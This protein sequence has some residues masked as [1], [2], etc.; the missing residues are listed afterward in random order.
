VPVGQ[1]AFDVAGRGNGT[2]QYRVVG[3][4][5]VEHGLIEGPASAART[6]AVD[7][8]YEADVTS[9]I[10]AAMVD[11]TVSFAGGVFQ[12]DQTLRNASAD[13]AVFVPLR[14]TITSVSSRS[15]KVKVQNADNGGDGVAS[16]AAFDYT[17]QAGSDQRLA[18]GETSGAR[19]LQFANPASEMFEFTAVVRGHLPDAANASGAGAS[20]GTDGGSAPS[21]TSTDGDAAG[22]TSLGGTLQQSGT[23]LR[24]VV[25]P[26]TR[27]VSVSLAR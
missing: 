14:F 20:G 24:F 8:R 15:G 19:R 4:F 16:P 23:A 17:A 12:F 21:S 10:Q 25:N 11:G 5:S 22:G 9:L 27:S 18:S 1:T 13:T 3:L 6:V 2:Y 26:L 7:R